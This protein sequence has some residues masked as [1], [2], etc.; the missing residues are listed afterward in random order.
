MNRTVATG[1]G[2][3]GQYAPPVAAM[4][5]S[6]ATCPEDL[7]LFMHHVPYT[8]VLRSGKAVIQHIYD[9]HYEGAD[10]AAEFVEL[11]KSLKGRVDEQ[12]FCEV[13]DR[14][15]YQAGHAIVWRD[16]VNNWFFKKSGIQ[17]VHG[18]VGNHSNRFEAEDMQRDGYEIMEV[19]PFEAASGEQA[20]QVRRGYDRGTVRLRYD[21]EPGWYD[22]VVQY[23]DEDDGI[24]RFTLS[25][26]D[27]TID[28]WQADHKLPTPTRRV[29]AHSS[30]RRRVQ[31][32]ALRRGDD[33]RI[34]GIS[35]GGERAV[36]D[37]V[38]ITPSRD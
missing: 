31:G 23:F 19:E 10:E 20:V 18:R 11:W 25:I 34:E 29:D 15:E 5:E 6:L 17:D 16:A 4:F 26:E 14:L 22:L 12:R 1:T 36:I 2:Y 33:I 27:Q 13:L 3:I 30:T 21:G 28:S 8:H 24:S 7:L 9:T 32:V 35:D 38:E 37:Y